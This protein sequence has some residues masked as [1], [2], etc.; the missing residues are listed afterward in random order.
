MV[1]TVPRCDPQVPCCH[2]QV[3]RMQ[4]C[5]ICLHVYMFYVHIK[6][7]DLG[8]FY[9]HMKHVNIFYVYMHRC[10]KET[11]FMWIFA[12][13]DTHPKKTSQ[14]DT[15]G[16]KKKKVE[17]RT[18]HAYMYTRPKKSQPEAQHTDRDSHPR[19]NNIVATR[20]PQPNI[21]PFAHGESI[22]LGSMP[23]S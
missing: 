5:A 10:T 13:R 17:V 12:K 22:I 16:Q 9:A 1:G 11:R 14:S 8:R 23:V 18:L 15:H 2:P 6:L 7:S 3:P 19:E 20:M 21:G 4:I